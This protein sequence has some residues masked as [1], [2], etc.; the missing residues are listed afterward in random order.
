[1]KL[2]KSDNRDKKRNK[3]INGMKI[4]NR[5]IFVVMAVIV[6]KGKRNNKNG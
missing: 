1:M 6:K 5:S 2:Q 4:D 3:K